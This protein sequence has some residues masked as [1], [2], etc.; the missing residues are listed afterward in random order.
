MIV[1]DGPHIQIRG[2]TDGVFVFV[3]DV[4]VARLEGESWVPLEPGYV[5]VNRPEQRWIEVFYEKPE[6]H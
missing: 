6:T 1:K 3:G 2:S 4:Q 5:V